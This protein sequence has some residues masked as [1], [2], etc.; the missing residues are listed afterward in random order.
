RKGVA[1]DVAK[2]GHD[3]NRLFL[4]K[5]V[6]R[7]EIEVQRDR[8]GNRAHGIVGSY[9][10]MGGLGDGGYLPASG[11]AAAVS[12]IGLDVGNSLL[13]G[14]VGK[15]PRSEEAFAGGKRAINTSR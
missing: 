11:E 6:R 10:Y 4:D 3:T 12:K 2:P 5:E 7:C 14:D 9:A 15:F 8:S 13:F 1:A